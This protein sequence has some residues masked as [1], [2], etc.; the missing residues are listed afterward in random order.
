MTPGPAG[1]HNWQPM[2]FHPD[3]GLVYIPVLRYIARLELWDETAPHVPLARNMGATSSR[4]HP[5]K[6]AELLKDIPDVETGSQIVA[7][8]PAPGAPRWIGPMQSV[9]AGGVLTT[10]GNLV[11][12]GSS[13][14]S[15]YF[16]AADTGEIVHDIPTGTMISAA[17]MTYELD[18]EQYI[19]VLAGSG[20]VALA[21]RVPDTA[22]WI[23]ENHSRLLVFKLGRTDVVFPPE[24]QPRIDQPAYDTVGLPNTAET[25]EHGEGLYMR[26]CNSCHR[27]QHSVNGYPNLWNLPPFTFDSL[28]SIV[29]D[30]TLAYAGMPGFSDILT[31]DDVIAIKAYIAHSQSR[32]GSDEEASGP[33][34]H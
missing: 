23:Y 31:T 6:D 2:A 29:L 34:A 21:N 19:A 26:F 16:Y 9:W 24:L 18:G 14:G 33:G 27:T 5:E 8:D 7:W 28:E 13:D 25:L 11:I 22:P 20:G 12:A 4:P 3:T 10:A 1:G 15:L 30:G 17:P 32:S